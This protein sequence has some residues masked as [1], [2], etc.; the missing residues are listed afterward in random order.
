MG[1]I[2]YAP[3]RVNP[4]KFISF[5]R[6]SCPI[7]SILRLE[8]CSAL[9]FALSQPAWPRAPVGSGHRCV[10]YPVSREHEGVL[11][12]V[13]RGGLGLQHTIRLAQSGQPMR[14][15]G[16]ARWQARYS[17]CKSATPRQWIGVSNLLIPIFEL[18]FKTRP[19]IP[20]FPLS[21]SLL[22][23]HPDIPTIKPGP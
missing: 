15:I 10:Q 4:P 2:G 7:D 22:G 14:F 19:R 16:M 1:G 9:L 3:P 11:T 8:R 20:F 13:G 6:R 21:L 18:H 23:P 17:N 5:H 12:K